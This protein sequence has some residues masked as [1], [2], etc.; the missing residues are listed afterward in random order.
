M[1]TRVSVILATTLFCAC[2]LLYSS[3]QHL[4]RNLERSEREISQLTETLEAKSKEAEVSNRELKK[5]S[6][7]LAV[8]RKTATKNEDK[9][10]NVISSKKDPCTDTIVSDDILSILQN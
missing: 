1:L 2:Y 5:L 4:K 7:N 8:L 9:I 3:N 6:N 10:S